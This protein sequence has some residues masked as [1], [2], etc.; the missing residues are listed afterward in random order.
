[1]NMRGK[2]KNIGMIHV[3]ETDAL[4]MIITIYV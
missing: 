4:V 3:R 2:E 1:M